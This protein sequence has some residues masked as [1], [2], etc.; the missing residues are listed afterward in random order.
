MKPALERFFRI[1]RFAVVLLLMCGVPSI[2]RAQFG[3]AAVLGTV[4]D[5]STAPIP[6][7]QVELLNLDTGVVQTDATDNTGSYQF[8]EAPV[9][10]YRVSVS[11]SGF[12][13]AESADFRLDAGARQRV[14][15]SLRV[16]DAT[17]TV[18]VE[19]AA[20]PL[21]TETSDRGEV[22]NHE[23]IVELP[24]NGRSS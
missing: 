18:E 17:Q 23:E 11:A 8:L 9:G 3:T 19:A 6:K 12:Q 10:R 5:P 14:E 13:K 7:A 4:V 15:M 1:S 20:S 2:S 16:G 24:L 22:I 21:Q